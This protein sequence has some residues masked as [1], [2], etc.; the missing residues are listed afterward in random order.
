MKNKFLINILIFFFY[1]NLLLAQD[2]L[3]EAKNITLDK[4][5]EISI[6]ENDVVV[7]TEGKIIESDYVEYDKKN[8]ILKIE[9]NVKAKDINNNIIETESAEYNENLK[10]FK[11][12]GPT[13][14]TTSEKYFLQGKNI[15][16]YTADKIIESKDDAVITDED[17]NKIYLQN[18]KYNS[19]QNIFKSVGLIKIEDN[20]DNSYQF[21]QIYI[22]TKRKE[23]LGTDIKAFI[24]DPNFK[25]NKDNKPRIFANTLKINN[26]Q[27][28]FD[29]SVFTV[30]DYRD[31]DKC[32]PW[33]I[34]ASKILHDRNKKTIFYDNAIIKIFDFPIFYIP[35]LSHPDPTVDRR[36]G[37]LVP[38][39]SDSKN[40][41][42]GISLPY[43]WAI[44]KDKNFT[45][46]S[47]F[48]AS[49]NPIFLGEYNQA[50]KNSNFLLDFGYTE[51]YKK[52]TVK[53]T[54]GEKSHIFSKFVKN[55]YN[56][57]ES[58]S[59]LSISFQDVSNDKYLKLYKIKSNLVDYETNNLESYLDFTHQN[60]V[61]FL[62]INASIYE[63]LNDD[64]NDK[65]EY[66]LPEIT[67]DRN[68][69]SNES[70]G[71]L[72]LQSNF[73]THLYDTNKLTNI[74]V[75]DLTWNFKEIYHESG[76]ESKLLANI[77]NINYEAKNVDNFKKDFTSD[78]YS[79][80][81]YLAELEL[82][83]KSTYTE[84][85]LTPKFLFRY[86]PGKMRTQRSD[87]YKLDPISAF[88]MDRLQVF[89]N[90]ETGTSGTLGFDYELR[91]NDIK[92]IDFS[93]AQI[94]NQKN[95]DK[96]PS[97]TSLDNKLSDLVGS[98]NYNTNNKF[99][100]NYNFSIDHNYSD[101]NYN[102]IGTSLAL[103]PI[104]IDFDY[105][106]ENKHIGDKQYL[107][108]KINFEN[109]RNSM[110]SIENKRNLVTDSSEF[111][112]LSYEYFNDCL[113]AGVV[114]RREFY[115]D[116]EL[117]SENSLMF[118]I[119]LTPFGNINSPSF[120]Q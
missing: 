70:V 76:F 63:T 72:D 80:F 23:I 57:D 104:K 111:Y 16:A 11:S 115:T 108:T 83:K 78:F 67:F 44:D 28:M 27:N 60:D 58:E 88:S 3:I 39:L 91:K 49:E 17:K 15:I 1:T 8:G 68:L 116:S 32:P 14:I 42:S 43:F 9:K 40:L 84:H 82:E 79:A 38:T 31:N 13:T 29:K 90:F 101:F 5:G 12:L 103:D 119:T 46:T 85:F 69:V 102:E 4:N 98:V 110:F 6:F 59:T 73:K 24:N 118:K 107:K 120:N 51:G 99:E 48:Y 56:D 112:N 19:N 41:G 10:I 50:F 77:K 7:K 81:G 62:G 65:Y 33:T 94:I 87:G 97:K 106:E 25:I 113:R 37:F 96:M 66:V 2:V 74:F 55:F 52:Q 117:E 18:F 64:Y 36:S 26:N 92:K 21:S 61:S 109:G 22:D 100:L 93:L 34:Q 86:A 75:N 20:T 53:K 89:N 30:C 95:N 47:K 114:Y 105:L 71:N 45:L 35:R 54:A